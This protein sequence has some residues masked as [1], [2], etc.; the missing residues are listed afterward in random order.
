MGI[1]KLLPITVGDNHYQPLSLCRLA[2]CH[3]MQYAGFCFTMVYEHWIKDDCV[4]TFYNCEICVGIY[5]MPT[6]VK[7]HCAQNVLGMM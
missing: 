1:S 5:I 2:E 3:G 6:Q 7:P 4:A